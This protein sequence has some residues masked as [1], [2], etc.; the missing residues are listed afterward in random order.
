MR[1]L[2]VRRSNVTYTVPMRD[3]LGYL[4]TCLFA[5][6]ILTMVLIFREVLPLLNPEDQLPFAVYGARRVQP[7]SGRAVID[8]WNEHA[9][10][11]PQS[12][13]RA[14]VISFVVA[15]IITFIGYPLWHVFMK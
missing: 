10:S 7:G 12:K 5:L 11:F 9:R 2:G 13:K 15:S 14:M 4:G 3:L 1:V 8:A 6:A